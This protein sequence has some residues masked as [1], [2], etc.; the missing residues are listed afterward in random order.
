MVS[1]DNNKYHYGYQ[2]AM[3]C[4]SIGKSAS[5]IYLLFLVFQILLS[6]LLYYLYKQIKNLFSF[7]QKTKLCSSSSLFLI[8]DIYRLFLLSGDI[9]TKQY[10]TICHWNLNSITNNGQ[11]FPL[12]GLYFNS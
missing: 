6:F 9:E 11:Q 5:F 3:L 1:K 10:L 4:H 7:V 2:S 12:L 8:Y